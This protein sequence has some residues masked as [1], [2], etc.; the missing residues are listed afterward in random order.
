MDS[1]DV[2]VIVDQ[3]AEKIGVAAG[4]IQPVAEAM[5]EEVVRSSMFA[6]WASLAAALVLAPVAL[7]VIRFCTKQC[8]QLED[9][10][11]A[12]FG[13]MAGGIAAGAMG[14]MGFLFGI[15]SFVDHYF[16]SLRPVTVVVEKFLN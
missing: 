1:N 8:S 10:T 15:E 12:H 3:L 7:L 11:D 6:A 9:G 14:V 16:D 4:K 13:F 2:S 5:V